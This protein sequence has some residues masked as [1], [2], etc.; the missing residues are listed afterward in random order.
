MPYRCLI[1]C[2]LFLISLNSFANVRF[3]DQTAIQLIKLNNE[4]S[5]SERVEF[6]SAAFLGA[7]YQINALGEGLIGRYDR[8]P[9]YRFD[10]FD[11]ESYVETVMALALAKSFLG[12]KKKL[13]QIRYE[14]GQVDFLH[15]NHFP[16]LG[17]IPNNKKNGNILELNYSIAGKKTRVA[18]ALINRR[19]WY[20][21]L[22]IERIHNTHFSL[23]EKNFYLHKLRKR[24]RALAYSEKAKIVYIPVAD[25]LN[26]PQLIERIPSASLVFLVGHDNYLNYRI[27]TPMNVFHMGFAIWNEG[28]IYLRMA[29]SRAK[30]VLDVRLKDYLKTYV[31][32]N[33]LKGISV[34]AIKETAD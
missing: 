6:Y 2:S 12:F 15:R 29:S 26:D 31:G 10:H 34:W 1:L 16:S 30:K 32:L 25:V 22:G 3:T 7:P 4:N 28:E 18:T 17:W 21:H 33:K 13:I 5:L 24:G 9:L 23:L 8:N 27:G 11:C 20:R 19:N 14:E